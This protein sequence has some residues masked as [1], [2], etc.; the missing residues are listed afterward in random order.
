MSSLWRIWVLASNTYREAVRDKLLYNLLLFAALMIASSILLAQVQIGKDDRIYRD[1]GLSAISFFGVLIA[2]FVGINLVHKELSTKTVYTMLAKPVRRW[3]FLLGKYF[4]LLTLLAVEVAIMSACFLG[5][6]VWTG[7]RFEMGLVWSIALIYCELSLV[8]AI[9]MFFSS[10]T[11][12]YL[13]GMFTIALWIIGH[14]LAD[15]RAFGSKSDLPGLKELLETLYWTLPN[16]DRL[17]IKADAS[18]G[19]PIE[20]ARVGAAAL[21]AWLYSFVPCRARRCCFSGAT[22]LARAKLVR[23]ATSAFRSRRGSAFVRRVHRQLST[24]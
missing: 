15:L 14:L 6:L 17:D 20:L 24:S 9:A 11:T 21:Y 10:F 3:E 2:I 23:C 19:R 5:V 1:V 8:T 12:P 4:G 7:A 18:A 22:S 16:L 13:S